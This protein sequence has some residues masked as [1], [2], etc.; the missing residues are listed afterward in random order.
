M[1][2]VDG[3]LAAMPATLLAEWMAFADVEPFGPRQEEARAAVLA[4]TGANVWRSGDAIRPHDLFPSLR[5]DRPID[6]ETAAIAEIAAWRTWAHV[7]GKV[8]DGH[9]RK[10]ER[11]DFCE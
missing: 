10:T 7:A 3:M 9:D 4:A 11:P 2:D 1:W 8:I 6:P 5:P